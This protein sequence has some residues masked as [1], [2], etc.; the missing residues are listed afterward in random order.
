MGTLTDLRQRGFNIS[1][2]LYQQIFN[3][4][5]VILKEAKET[6]F[7]QCITVEFYD[8]GIIK[9]ISKGLDWKVVLTFGIAAV[10]L[11]CVAVYFIGPE[12]IVNAMTYMMQHKQDTIQ[13][14]AP[15]LSAISTH[16]AD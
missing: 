7:Y 14:A 6:P 5:F 15:I 8:N 2:E 3:A 1:P 9:K 13:A 11:G 10:M 12:H 16:C 4:Q